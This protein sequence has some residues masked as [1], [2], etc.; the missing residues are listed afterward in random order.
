MRFSNDS[1][2]IGAKPGLNRREYR[3]C[4]RRAW[5]RLEPDERKRSRPVLRGGSGSNAIPLPDLHALSVAPSPSRRRPFHSANRA[6]VTSLHGAGPQERRASVCGSAAGVALRL[7][8][9]KRSSPPSAP[10]FPLADRRPKPDCLFSPCRPTRLDLTHENA[11]SAIN[12]T[13]QVRFC[14]ECGEIFTHEHFVVQSVQCVARQ[15]FVLLR[16]ENQPNGRMFV[17]LRPMDAGIIAV[18]I[19]LPDVAVNERTDLQVNDDETT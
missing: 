7:R 13:R 6:L 1:A 18:K 4:S 10:L 12:F 3:L 2:S 14:R 16:A 11:A 5:K 9:A 19:H 8:F 17:G 15:R